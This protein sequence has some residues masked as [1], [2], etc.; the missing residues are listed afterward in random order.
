MLDA[1]FWIL[2][3]T[4]AVG[5]AISCFYLLEQPIRGL[6]RWVSVG[7]GLLGVTGSVLFFTVMAIGAPD[8]SGMGQVATS[9]LI[10]T[11]TGA[12]VV[13]LAQVRRRRPSGLV[14][15]LHATL[16]VAGYIVLAAYATTPQ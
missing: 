6:A 12:A 15:A 4:V 9:L 14:V 5:L 8:R 13:V 2:G 11:L 16:G 10:G 1:A 7:H 3:I